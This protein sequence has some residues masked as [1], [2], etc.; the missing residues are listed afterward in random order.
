[1]PL[2]AT[3][4]G[5]LVRVMSPDGLLAVETEHVRPLGMVDAVGDG[6]AGA[7]VSSPARSGVTMYVHQGGGEIQSSPSSPGSSLY[8]LP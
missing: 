1:M 5:A 2:E 6:A 8:P 4:P 7:H 3:Y